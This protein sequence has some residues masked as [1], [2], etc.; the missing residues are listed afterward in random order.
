MGKF[1][2][3]IKRDALNGVTSSNPLP[4]TTGFGSPHPD[5]AYFQMGDGTVKFLSTSMNLATFQN[6]SKIADGDIVIASAHLTGCDGRGSRRTC[7]RSIPMMTVEEPQLS[8]ECPK[9][10][11]NPLKTGVFKGF[12]EKAPVGVEPTMTDL[13]SVALATWPRSQ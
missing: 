13:Q 6:L 10:R 7:S 9:E 8:T 11:E 2:V 5:G 1:E 3:A 12:S 4:N